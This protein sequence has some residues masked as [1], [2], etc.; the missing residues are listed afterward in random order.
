MKKILLLALASCLLFT[1]CS[2][3]ARNLSESE[4]FSEETLLTED[5]PVEETGEVI[6]SGEETIEATS[7]EE[8][9]T[10]EVAEGFIPAE[11]P[12]LITFPERVSLELG[13]ETELLKTQDF[14]I[15]VCPTELHPGKDSDTYICDINITDSDS[16]KTMLENVNSLKSV[17]GIILLFVMMFWI[18]STLSL[19]LI[20]IIMVLPIIFL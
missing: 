7:S 11:I 14:T 17:N 5:A 10:E 9:D 6:S 8:E 4:K 20:L 3:K 12:E 15:S 18:M 2:K 13:Q 19:Q 1:S 16:N